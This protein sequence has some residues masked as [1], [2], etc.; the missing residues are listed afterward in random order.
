MKILLS[1]FLLGATL[2][3]GSRE[4]LMD[5]DYSGYAVVYGGKFPA[6]VIH[7]ETRM[8]DGIPT[9]LRLD[10][11]ENFL[12]I[13]GGEKVSLVNGGTLYA[14]VK[15]RREKAF[16][17]LFFKENE[18]LLGYYQKN[19]YFNMPN[20]KKFNAP[21]YCGPVPLDEWCRAAA[22]V[23]VKDGDYFVRLH[24]NGKKTEETV[25]RALDYK[26]SNGKLTI[27]KGWGGVWFLS[28]EIAILKVFDV[29]LTDAEIAELDKQSPYRFLPQNL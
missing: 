15:F 10:G 5:Y 21:V 13:P 8:S 4:P 25:F 2:C 28:G 29:P 6:P 17:M 11:K 22:V 24:L 20:G 9:S 12:T 19:L 26:T 16:G 14:V 7:G 27:G 1:V 3:S 23:S 18:F